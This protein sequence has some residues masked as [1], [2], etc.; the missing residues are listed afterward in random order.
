M[1]DLEQA[2]TAPSPR[3]VSLDRPVLVSLL[4][5]GLTAYALLF[6]PWGAGA[7]LSLLA[8]AYVAGCSLAMAAFYGSDR[9]A[10][11]E[12]ALLAAIWAVGVAIWGVL[13]EFV[14]VIGSPMPHTA[15]SLLLAFWAAVFLFTPGFL[16]WQGLAYGTR[17]AWRRWVR[18]ERIDL[19]AVH[20]P[21]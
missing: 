17:L 8:L 1:A 10:G 20:Q 4:V 14:L 7:G 9:H 19:A 18:H 12:I 11:Q 3:R 13:F 21:A 16:L 15:G 5:F 2:T 6:N